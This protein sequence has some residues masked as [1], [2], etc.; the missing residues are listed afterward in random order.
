MILQIENHGLVHGQPKVGFV[1][2]L[3]SCALIDFLGKPPGAWPG[4]VSIV[5]VRLALR[6]AKAR[7]CFLTWK[8]VN[9]ECS[10]NIRSTV[11][12][13]GIPSR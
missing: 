9:D 10:I 3:P 4:I 11:E 7:I 2:I 12:V 13:W 6:F 5:V 1:V 8:A